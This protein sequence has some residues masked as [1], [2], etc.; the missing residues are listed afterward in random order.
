[1]P[2]PFTPFF[3]IIRPGRILYGKRHV[4]GICLA[5]L[6]DFQC[7]RWALTALRNEPITERDTMVKKIQHKLKL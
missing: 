3:R 5:M 2:S 1:M 4:N 7:Y 6:L